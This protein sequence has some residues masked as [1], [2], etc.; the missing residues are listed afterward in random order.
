M[1]TTS[2]FTK[3]AIG[4]GALREKLNLGRTTIWRRLK[5]DATFPRPVTLGGRAQRWLES[6][7]DAW[8]QAKAAERKEVIAKE[9]AE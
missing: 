5:D 6:E 9:S 8:M 1:D 2:Q 3:R 7:V 4:I